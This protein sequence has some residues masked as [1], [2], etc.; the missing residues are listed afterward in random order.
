MLVRFLTEPGVGGLIVMVVLVLCLSFYGS[1]VLWIA[2]AEES[3]EAALTRGRQREPQ[4]AQ[5][6][7]ARS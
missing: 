1:L 2:R 4:G 3:A 7:G 5:L 6:E